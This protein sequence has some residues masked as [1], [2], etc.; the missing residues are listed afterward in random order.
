MFKPIIQFIVIIGIGSII[1]ISTSFLVNFIKEPDVIEKQIIVSAPTCENSHDA[2]KKLV[3]SNQSVELV[4]DSNMYAVNNKFVNGKQVIITRLGN[5][6][7]ACGYLYVRARKDGKPLEEKYNSVFVATNDFGGHILPKGRIGL[8][9]PDPNKTEFLLP[10]SSISYLPSIPFN[11]EAQDYKIDNWVNLL[12]VSSQ[13]KFFI[14]LSVPET[15]G[16]IEE[17]RIAYKCW[18]SKTGKETQGCQLSV[19]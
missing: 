12:N 14:G 13:T 11:P 19:K 16:F 17:V 6:Q 4:S 18:D 2:Y 15:D 8:N 10:L 5:D 3:D 7:I 1:I 9:N